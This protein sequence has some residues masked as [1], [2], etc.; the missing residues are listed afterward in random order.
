[1]LGGKHEQ[2]ERAVKVLPCPNRPD[3][4]RIAISQKVL[5]IRMTPVGESFQECDRL[6]HKI[7]SFLLVDGAHG[8]GR[9][10]CG[11]TGI[12][13]RIRFRS[14]DRQI[15]RL[16][17][18][19]HEDGEFKDQFGVIGLFRVGAVEFECFVVGEQGG[20]G[21]RAQVG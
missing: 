7:I 5:R 2:R 8:R 20:A 18:I 15:E 17:G 3:P 14:L 21:S 19:D 10:A 13:T 4:V 12:R 6:P 9:M 11:T 16:G 1:M